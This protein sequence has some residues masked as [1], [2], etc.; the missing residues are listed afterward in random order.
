[1]NEFEL[2]RIDDSKYNNVIIPVKR[3][4]STLE[5]PL[6]IGLHVQS[7]T[8][9]LPDMYPWE[10]NHTCLAFY[11]HIKDETR[12]Y[13]VNDRYWEREYSLNGNNKYCMDVLVDYLMRFLSEYSIDPGNRCIHLITH[14]GHQV[15]SQIDA[16]KDFKFK[17]INKGLYL[18]GTIKQTQTDNKLQLKIIDLYSLINNSIGSIGNYIGL[19]RVTKR[20]LY[21]LFNKCFDQ[22]QVVNMICTNES[23]DSSKI[24]AQIAHDAYIRLRSSFLANNNIDLLN[25]YTMS[26]IAGY[27]LRRD[28]LIKPVVSSKVIRQARKQKKTLSDGIEKYYDVLQKKE[29]FDGDLNVRK[30]SLL[31]YHGARIETFCRGRFE[32]KELIY[33]DVDSLYPSS[34]ILQPLPLADTKWI[35]Y[36]K[37]NADKFLDKAEGFVEVEFHYSPETFYPCLPVSGLRDGI[38]YFPLSGITYCTIAELR[39][40]I[41]LGLIDYKIISGFGFY[42]TRREKDHPLVYYMNEILENKQQTQKGTL[43]YSI[44]KML[45]NSLVG[46]FAQRD[47]NNRTLGMVN[48]GGIS[49]DAYK[50]LDNYR[51]STVGNLWY[52]EWASLI[53]GKARALMSEFI[54][55]GTYFVSSDSV[56]LPKDL[57]INCDSLDELRSVGS[58]L[59]KE[60]HVDHGVIIRAR[61]Y[62]LNPLNENPRERHLARHAV[63]CKPEDFRKIMIEGFE[64]RNIP[65][66]SFESKKTIKYEK[67]ILEGKELNSVEY[68]QSTIDIKWDGKRKLINEIENPFRDFSWSEAM[69][70]R[71]VQNNDLRRPD[72]E[73][74]GRKLGKKLDTD[75]K[76]DITRLYEEGKK[77][78]D[79][80]EKLN[81]SKGYVS[82]VFQEINVRQGIFD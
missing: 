16:P 14:N 58:N 82:K 57:N 37:Q 6:I 5:D 73:K 22:S 78:K 44:Y 20:E 46:K 59:R 63:S 25:F 32:D 64:T 45:M 21:E 34:S 48:K 33:Y 30:Y 61:L 52:P 4:K 31:A 74:P 8:F 41:K 11:F 13:I 12:M 47:K 29:I 23:G 81:V 68:K 1:M 35:K 79:I 76:R 75:I 49:R 43:E 70:E 15:L 77:Q 7:H 38:L 42:P 18:E 66:L 67:S 69:D 51:K 65:D 80:A 3:E 56:L 19:P 24:D 71:E 2:S 9:G 39:M 72:K 62:G 54:S 28:Y 36:S 27:I 53:L 26:S 17:P 40:A 60:F 10:I 50:K 55:M